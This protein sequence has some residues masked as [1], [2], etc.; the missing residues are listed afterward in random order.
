MLL[1]TIHFLVESLA[2]FLLMYSTVSFLLLLSVYQFYVLYNTKFYN[3]SEQ[4]NLKDWVQHDE[5]SN[6]RCTVARCLQMF[7]SS[8]HGGFGGRKCGH[9]IC[10]CTVTI[11][12]YFAYHIAQPIRRDPQTWNGGWVGACSLGGFSEARTCGKGTSDPTGANLKLNFSQILWYL[13]FWVVGLVHHF[14]RI[15]MH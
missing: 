12:F 11:L 4:Q 9:V 6:L 5:A 3:N 14:N 8:R 7:S 10:G 15:I 1:T 13:I 2:H